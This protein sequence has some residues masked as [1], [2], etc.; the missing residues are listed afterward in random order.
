MSFSKHR[1]IF[2]PQKYL[3]IFALALAASSVMC[4]QL[5][6]SVTLTMSVLRERVYYA[7]DCSDK[8]LRP[9]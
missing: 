5:D 6:P 7:A 3:H 8:M 9:E 4:L 2:Y 1:I